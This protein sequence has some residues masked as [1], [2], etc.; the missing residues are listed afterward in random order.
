M[1]PLASARPLSFLWCFHF[2]SVFWPWGGSCSNQLWQE[3]MTLRLY[4]D[5]YNTR[6]Q[7][8]KRSEKRSSSKLPAR[9]S[10]TSCQWIG[11]SMMRVMQHI[12]VSEYCPNDPRWKQQ[13]QNSIEGCLV[14][15]VFSIN[16]VACLRQPIHRWMP[17]LYNVDLNHISY[18]NLFSLDSHDCF[19]EL[20]KY[21]ARC[22]IT[23]EACH[24]DLLQQIKNF[25]P[26][27]MRSAR[28]WVGHPLAEP[29]F[30]TP[31]LDN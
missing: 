28:Q 23:S 2:S 3:Y 18:F 9:Q 17:C 16:G 27:S 24:L 6:Y 7:E 29:R 8:R 14:S 10:S 20:Q 19:H 1:A 30:Q 13:N 22:Q 21:V 25:P 12:L 15:H 5:I 26:W 4:I 11:C 31:K